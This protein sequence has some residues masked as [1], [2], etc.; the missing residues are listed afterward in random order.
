MVPTVSIDVLERTK[1][2]GFYKREKS[3]AGL[4]EKYK[5]FETNLI[6]LEGNAA[7]R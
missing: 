7:I 5:K 1:A 3:T 4:N 2:E 6:I